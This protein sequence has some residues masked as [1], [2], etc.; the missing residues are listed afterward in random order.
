MPQ[1]IF[2]QN[3][4]KMKNVTFLFALLMAALFMSCSQ[5][6]QHAAPVNQNS[7]ALVVPK[8]SVSNGP[9]NQLLLKDGRTANPVSGIPGF[10]TM[11]VGA[12]LSLSFVEASSHGGV[13]DINVTNYASADT[14]KFVPK[15]STKGNP[16]DLSGTYAGT[17]YK[18]TA[19]STSI[20]RGTASI[21]FTGT[22]Y[23]CP[24]SPSGYPLAGSGTWTATDELITFNDAAANTDNHLKG[25]FHYYA[26]EEELYLWSVSSN[27]YV[28]F[29]MKKN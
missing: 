23:S 12:K 8:A 5:D 3:S 4:K 18:A 15:P 11:K 29:S 10:S 25:S 27:G 17:V 1:H 20:I 28:S 26:K 16:P 14:S 7:L 24:A 9:E 13:V 21:T 2:K 6:S 22:N 19:D